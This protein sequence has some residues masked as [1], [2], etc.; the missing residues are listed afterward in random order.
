MPNG[1]IG[2]VPVAT[3][4]STARSASEAMSSSTAE[5][6]IRVAT[7]DCDN[8]SALSEIIV[9]ETAVAVIVSPHISEI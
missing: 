5:V 2:A 4:T 6:M 3:G 9:S 1:S 7:G 8:P